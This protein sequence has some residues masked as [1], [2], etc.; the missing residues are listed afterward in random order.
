MATV[1][2]IFALLIV[3]S[4]YIG[5]ALIFLEQTG[6][7]G[8]KDLIMEVPAVFLIAVASLISVIVFIETF[9]KDFTGFIIWFTIWIII[10]KTFF[11]LGLRF[12]VIHRIAM[13][14]PVNFFGVN[15]MTVNM[16][17][18]VTAWGT[19]EGM[20]KCLIVGIVG[21]I[22]FALTGILL[23]RKKDV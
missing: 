14:M 11:Y 3:L 4:V 5:S 8:L 21:V 2:A 17:Q 12:D 18:S 1:S 22:I 9:E 13:W 15:G 23:L 10:P 20:A 6:P 19:I 16:T 7:V